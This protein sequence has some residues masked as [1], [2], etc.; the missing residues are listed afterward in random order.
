[1]SK[2]YTREQLRQLYIKLPQEIKDAASADETTNDIERICERNEITDERVGAI[3]DLI[4]NVL[5]GV[6][7]P[8]DFQST[9]EKEIGLKK[10]VAKKVAQEINRFVFYPVKP[11][12]EQL[13]NIG[14]TKPDSQASSFAPASAEATAGKKATEDKEEKP[15]QPAG[16]DTYREPIE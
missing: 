15:S 11:A 16:K 13:Y 1:M 2:E 3:S 12:L 6:L 7:P 8:E 14:V 10:D 5:F 9:L 4:R